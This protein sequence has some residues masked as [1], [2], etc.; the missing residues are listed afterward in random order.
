MSMFT[1]ARS[2]MRRWRFRLAFLA[3]LL[4][5]LAPSVSHA[6]AASRPSIP[7]DVCSEHGG[8]ALAVAAALLTQDQD[9]HHGA[10]GLAGD[11]GHCLAHAGMLGLPPAGLSALP[12]APAMPGRP[13]LFYHAPRPLPALC[14]AAPRGPPSFA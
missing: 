8:P 14:A 13:Y 3:V 2:T 10:G 5:A 6:L 7:I 4:N 12:P 11:C 9:H 1:N